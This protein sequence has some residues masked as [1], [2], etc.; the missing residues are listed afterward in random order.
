MIKSNNGVRDSLPRHTAAFFILFFHSTNPIQRIPTAVR[1]QSCADTRESAG[2]SPV[3]CKTLKRCE[4]RKQWGPPWPERHEDWLPTESPD[5]T[6]PTSKCSTSLPPPET[7]LH[8]PRELTSVA[9][10]SFTWAAICEASAESS[11]QRCVIPRSWGWMLCDQKKWSVLAGF[12]CWVIMLVTEPLQYDLSRLA[13][14]TILARSSWLTS[15]CLSKCNCTCSK[16]EKRSLN[17]ACIDCTNSLVS[18]KRPRNPAYTAT[19]MNCLCCIFAAAKISQI[20]WSVGP[21]GGSNSSSTGFKRHKRSSA[22]C[23]APWGQPGQPQC[24]LC[25]RMKKDLAKATARSSMDRMSSSAKSISVTV[26]KHNSNLLSTL[27][28][29]WSWRKSSS[30]SRSLG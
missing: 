4:G 11:D 9:S 3:G 7:R 30:A 2:A 27:W 23:F 12:S 8:E 28:T 21:S 25:S 16:D 26:R 10:S 15:P 1:I 29:L 22:T 20:R 13:K 17:F 5:A 24:F 18:G 6:L 14:P 19:M